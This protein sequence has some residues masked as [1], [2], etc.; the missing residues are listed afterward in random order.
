[1]LK[2]AGVNRIFVCGLAYD[3]CVGYSALHGAEEG[4]DTFGKVWLLNSRTVGLILFSVI[5]DAC[6]AI[7]ASSKES[8]TKDLRAQNVKLLQADDVKSRLLK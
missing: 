7:S 3:V 1:M 8:M 5:V 4:F 2:E 6:R